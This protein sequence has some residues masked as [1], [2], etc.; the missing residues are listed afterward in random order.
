M[1]QQKFLTILII[2]YQLYV[3]IASHTIFSGIRPVFFLRRILSGTIMD[4]LRKVRFGVTYRRLFY[5][6]YQKGVPTQELMRLYPEELTRVS[7]IALMEIPEET[8]NKV[9]QEKGTLKRLLTL[10]RI[11]NGEYGK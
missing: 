11:L 8:L 4:M 10:K 5:L 1:R 2:F 3:I 6:K 7:E 9:I